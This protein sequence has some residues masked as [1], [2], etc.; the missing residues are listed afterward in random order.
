MPKMV[1]S[2]KYLILG[3]GRCGSSLLA[4]IL[5]HAGANLGMESKS[6][7]E[8]SR[9]YYEHHLVHE[10]E[11]WYSR[12][13]KIRQSLIPELFGYKY[14][15]EKCRVCFSELFKAVDYVKSTNLHGLVHMVNAMGYNPSI[16]GLWRE[17]LPTI[18][19][20]SKKSQ[21]TSTVALR[22]WHETNQ[23]ILLLM[24]IYDSCLIKF[25]HLQDLNNEDW[26]YPLARLTG[27][28]ARSL[29]EARTQL[30]DP[31]IREFRAPFT[32]PQHI[33]DL[34]NDLEKYTNAVFLNSDES[35]LPV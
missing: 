10:A 33:V 24:N 34:R 9:G 5:D 11:K 16:I 22:Q 3:T 25:E 19:S 32:L 2:A 35:N 31:A 8:H 1:L 29:L 30:S 17:P 15:M 26:V 7:W 13:Q 23:N 28:Q 21:K 27:L 4:A 6:G 18:Y 20:H 14:C 12:A